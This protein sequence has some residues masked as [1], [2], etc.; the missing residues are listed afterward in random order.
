MHRPVLLRETVELLAVRPGGTY[1]DG[2][3]GGG[4]HARALAE[5]V[6]AA[7]RLIGI[8]RDPEAV[9]RAGEALKGLAAR[10]DL[11]CGGFDEMAEI[12]ARLGVREADGI[13]LDLGISS[14]QLDSAERGFSFQADG[15]LDMRMNR[16]G[17]GRTAGDIVNSMP[18]RELADLI[19]GLGEEPAARR[20]ARAV[21]AARRDA[22]LGWTSELAALVSRAKGGRQG[23]IHPATQT[24]QA[25]RIAVNDEL[26]ALERGLDA[27]L[28]L[29]RPGG[30]MAVIAFHSLEDRLVKHFFRRHVTRYEA[31]AGGGQREVGDDPRVRLVTGRPVEASGDEAAENPRARSAKLRVA[32]REA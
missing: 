4:G 17:Q 26:G 25:L 27:G 7:G 3:L 11:V 14:D 5:A 32:E 28:G 23:R 9:A 30:R 1:I 2:T 20:I 13:L 6:G 22:P 29:L 31:L 19:F 15:P 12:A 8:D 21:V 18:E 10:V 16:R 24:F